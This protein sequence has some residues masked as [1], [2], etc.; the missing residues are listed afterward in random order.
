[1]LTNIERMSDHCS[2]IASYIIDESNNNL[3]SHENIIAYRKKEEFQDL[4]DEYYKRY[5][6]LIKAV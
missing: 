5:N 1:M 4:F 6:D 3:K 2:N